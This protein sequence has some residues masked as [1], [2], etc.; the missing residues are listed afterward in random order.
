MSLFFKNFAPVIEVFGI[1]KFPAP[2]ISRAENRTKDLST[3]EI[4]QLCEL[5]I[6]NCE[7][8]PS[9]VKIVG[10]AAMIRARRSIKKTET[11]HKEILCLHCNDLGVVRIESAKHGDLLMKCGSVATTPCGDLVCHTQNYWDLPKWQESF[12]SQF[13][14]SIVPVEWLKPSSVSSFSE[15]RDDWIAKIRI[16]QIKLKEIGFESKL[17]ETKI[18]PQ[19]HANAITPQTQPNTTTTTY[20]APLASNVAF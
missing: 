8:A 5:L 20:N 12:N 17:P 1:E 7:R 15:K 18:T 10:F 19:C 2:L 3:E 4:S 6:D 9:I 14:K 13:K 11:I 16:S